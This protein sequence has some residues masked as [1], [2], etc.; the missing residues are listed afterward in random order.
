MNNKP[1]ITQRV[2]PDTR[3]SYGPDPITDKT[4]KQL[5]QALARFAPV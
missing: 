1:F 2:P 5:G 3:L 4:R